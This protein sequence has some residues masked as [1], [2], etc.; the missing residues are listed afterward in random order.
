MSQ[1]EYFRMLS[2]HWNLALKIVPNCYESMLVTLKE[3]FLKLKECLIVYVFLSF[4]QKYSI[5]L[6][7]VFHQHIN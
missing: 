1:H 4:Q 3:N 6:Y 5:N 2:K 7:M